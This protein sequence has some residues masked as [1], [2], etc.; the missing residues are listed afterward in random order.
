[1]AHP[2]TLLFTQ[3]AWGLLVAGTI[4]GLFGIIHRYYDLVWR[5]VMNAMKGYGIGCVKKIPHFHSSKVRSSQ[6]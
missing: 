1:M 3:E 4:A 5:C 2:C 6:W